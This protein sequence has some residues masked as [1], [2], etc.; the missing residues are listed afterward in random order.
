MARLRHTARKFVI[1]F[2]PSRLAELPLRRPVTGQSSHLER[3][4]HRLHEEQEC[5]RQELEQQG[6][7]FSLQ[8]EIESVRSC[9]PMLPLEAP[10]PPPLSAPAAGVA[11]GGD[12]DDTGGDSSPSF[13]TDLSA[14]QEPEGWVAQPI[15][16]DAA[17]ECHFHDAL[18]TLLHQTLGR[19]TWSIE[20]RCVVFQHSRGVYPDRWEA[21]YLV[22]R[23][24]NSLQGAE[25]CS[26]HYSISKQNSAEA[27]MQDVA[28]RALSHYCLVL[29][30]VADGLNLK[31]YPCHPSCSTGSVIVSPVGEDNPRLSSTVNLATV[32][33]TELDHALD[34]LSRAHAEIAQLR[35]ERAERRHLKIGSPAPVGTQHPYRSPR[36]GHQAYGNPDCRTKI[37][38]EPCW[39]L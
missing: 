33:N 4:H 16:R 23:P 29:G 14:D 38:L 36:R 32:L 21:T 12:L 27:A 9:S 6:S 13:N 34:E 5:R 19:R 7:S 35:A 15:T 8:Q 17:R 22:R 26:K 11:V 39:V 3:L 28:R 31:Y 2:L 1:P 37:D 25:V 18:D 30:G 10:P 20:Y 24:E